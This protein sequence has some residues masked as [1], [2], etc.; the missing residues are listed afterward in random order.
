[1]VAGGFLAAIAGGRFQ[2]AFDLGAT[3]TRLFGEGWEEWL[4]LF[5]S[6]ALVGFG[7][8]MGG[9]CTSGHALSGV[10]RFIPS[11]LVATAMFFGA[12]VVVSFLVEFLLS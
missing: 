5:S 9:G 7:T 12:A 10:S 1:M 2:L 4:V 8:Q 11:S 6:G 3:H